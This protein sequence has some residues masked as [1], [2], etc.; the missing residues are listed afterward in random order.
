MGIFSTEKFD[1]VKTD[2]ETPQEL[3]DYLN[4]EFHFTLDAAASNKYRW[5]DTE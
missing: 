2:W 4:K 5:Y 1:G 3:F